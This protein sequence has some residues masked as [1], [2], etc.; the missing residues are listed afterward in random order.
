MTVFKGFLILVKRNSML[1]LLYLGIFMTI[2]LAVQTVTK[3]EGVT[4][5]EEERLNI[6][7]I[8]L[9]HS[10]LSKGLKSYLGEKH[11]LVD[12]KNEKAVIQEEL[13]YRN[14][15]Y[16]V[17]IPKGYE[18]EWTKEDTVLNTRKIQG[19]AS[20]FYVDQQINTFLNSVK[21][22]QSA[23]FTM[24]ESVKEAY[25]SSE[26][27]ADVTLIDKNGFGGRVPPHS[28]MFQYMPYFMLA[29]LCYTIGFIMIAFRK[30]D[31]RRRML[32]SAISSRK[33][34]T[35]MILG[36]IIMGLV[37]WVI[38]IGLILVLY[39]K[40]FLADSNAKY[41]L[42]NTFV[43]MLVSLSFAF[44]VGVIVKNE[45]LVN[46]LVNVISLG[47]CFTCGV[48][49][50]LDVLGSGLKTAAQFLPVY[51]YEVVN[52]ILGSNKEFV[53][54]QMQQIW[55]GIGIQVL[56]AVAIIGLGMMISKRKEQE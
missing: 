51:W 17:T 40:E 29:V 12:V 7:V 35:Q 28:F 31:V 46:N 1:C 4:K 21:V 16:V 24:E 9:D 50:S 3:G 36:Y 10:T 49:V 18:K 6:A 2:V 44:F 5:F 15:Y 53:S 37:F 38:C 32:C 48:F 11:T 19:A 52:G 13:F 55:K 23:G 33:Q 54:S 26:I 42:L 14:I 25:K 56:F 45:D 47:M 27:K 39:G 41:Y 43:L 8:D 22:F 20:A 30:K 34:N